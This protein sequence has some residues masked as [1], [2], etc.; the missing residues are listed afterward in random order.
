MRGE[1][2]MSDTHRIVVCAL[3]VTCVGVLGLSAVSIWAARLSPDP[4]TVVG[5]AGAIGLASGAAGVGLCRRRTTQTVDML[6]SLVAAIGRD[7]TPSSPPRCGEDRADLLAMQLVALGGRLASVRQQRDHARAELRRSRER[8]RDLVENLPVGIYRNE[9]QQPGRFLMANPAV[10]RIF[11]F[12]SV[13][14]LT[15]HTVDELYV[16][17]DDRRR[18]LAGLRDHGQV[19]EQFRMKRR[20]G[21]EFWAA[22][23]ARAIADSQG[24][25]RYLDGIIE[26][27][28]DRKRTEQ[29]MAQTLEKLRRFNRL[30]VDRERRMIELKGMVNEYA[31]RAGLEPPFDMGFV[32]AAQHRSGASTPE[33]CS[34]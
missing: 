22:V 25:R 34:R 21:T 18:L 27:I 1:N 17:P 15:R 10:A 33:E 6:S 23:T 28:S 26:D 16:D 31:V 29:R 12:E 19:A 8:Y 5:L 7:Q 2:A 3:V 4:I 24:R 11:G 13:E 9:L 20:D 30:A 14:Q 32:T